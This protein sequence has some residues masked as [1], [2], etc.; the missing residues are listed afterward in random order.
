MH[1]WQIS[2]SCTGAN[3]RKWWTY[4]NTNAHFVIERITSTIGTLSLI[5]N[6]FI[7]KNQLTRHMQEDSTSVARWMWWTHLNT[8]A[9][10]SI[11]HLKITIGAIYRYFKHIHLGDWTH[12]AH[13]GGLDQRCHR[14]CISSKR[15]PTLGG[16]VILVAP[17]RSA[18]PERKGLQRAL[19]T[20][21]NGGAAPWLWIITYD[22]CGEH[23]V[24]WQTNSPQHA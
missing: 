13:V 12:S 10:F 15:A 1:V 5:S 2:I 18:V 11:E 14:V 23:W 16:T 7:Q 4:L 17:R 8:N 21:W 19:G 6:T 22:R 24:L 3:T 20:A 9:H